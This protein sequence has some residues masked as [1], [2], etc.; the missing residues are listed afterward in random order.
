VHR[1]R[2]SLRAGAFHTP[3]PTTPLYAQ[4]QSALTSPSCLIAPVHGFAGTRRR[5]GAAYMFDIS[6]GRAEAGGAHESAGHLRTAAVL[7]VRFLDLQTPAAACAYRRSRAAAA[8]PPF[9]SR[10]FRAP[11]TFFLNAVRPV[12][13]RARRRH[14]RTAGTC[15]S[16]CSR[17]RAIKFMLAAVLFRHAGGV[18]LRHSTGLNAIWQ[19][20]GIIRCG[21]N[22]GRWLLWRQRRAFSGS[23]ARCLRCLYACAIHSPLL[24]LS[25]RHFMHALFRLDLWKNS[26]AAA[27]EGRDM[28]LQRF[29]APAGISGTPALCLP[30]A[31][32][33]V[34]EHPRRGGCV[35]WRQSDGMRADMTFRGRWRVGVSV[36][37]QQGSSWRFLYDKRRACRW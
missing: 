16:G 1:A 37:K 11:G 9:F 6:G 22:A 7:A 33:T 26:A 28:A 30:A 31:D 29:G 10:C 23:C 34:S 4:R 5:R 24:P 32:T 27:P 25:S 13:A 35:C 12:T 17:L 2:S 8:L 19:H 20:A 21:G 15:A 3:P 18:C 36:R 14:A